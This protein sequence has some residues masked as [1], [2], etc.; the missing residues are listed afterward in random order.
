MIS[1]GAGGGTLVAAPAVAPVFD[2]PEAHG[3]KRDGVT[4]DTAAIKAAVANVITKAQANGTNYGEV[5]FS[6][7]TYFCSA[8]P[9]T[10]KL[11]R[12][13]IPLPPIASTGQKFILVLRG[14]Y[15]GSD[16]PHWQ[17]TVAQTA[18]A[19]ILTS[20]NL[21]FDAG[22]G[23]ASVIGG[24][25]TQQFGATDGGFS[26]MLVIID[27][28][29]VMSN[30][31]NPLHV[32]VDL[33]CIAQCHIKALTVNGF[34]IPGLNQ[35]TAATPTAGGLGIRMPQVGNN[36][37]QKVDTYA[38]EGYTIGFMPSEHTDA[39]RVACIYCQ[40]G[41]GFQ[42]TA[43][44][45]GRINYLSTEGCQYHLSTRSGAQQGSA[46]CNLDI[47]TWD[48]EDYPGIPTSFHIDDSQNLLAGV[49]EG[50]RD[51]NTT[52]PG[53]G[54]N[55]VYN[56]GAKFR[57]LNAFRAPGH[58]ASPGLPATTVA[59]P[60]PF[61]RDAAVTI[62][63]GTVTVIAID[64]TSIGVTSGTIVLPANKSITLTYSVAPTW[65]WNLL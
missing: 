59:L 57:T 20:L 38:C 35:G 56:G 33:A 60:N 19:T 63:G 55:P 50:F 16:F 49:C 23:S 4:D 40:Q 47:G 18:G 54:Q 45:S 25:T 34:V 52:G 5:W 36:D 13:Q 30:Y 61:A 9:D 29:T 28:L 44:D 8:A 22:L 17:Q 53:L 39:D 37:Y 7:G 24:P 21:A 1:G 43:N 65:V 32:A 2:T 62:T 51:N 42:S 46:L 11:G 58:I 26:N 64:G 3:A 31:I 10:T 14:V 27:G 41:V 12:A 48:C 6:A 15:D